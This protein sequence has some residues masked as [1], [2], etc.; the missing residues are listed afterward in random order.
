MASAGDM[1]CPMCGE[2]VKMGAKICRHCKANL[3]G[4]APAGPPPPGYYS[5]APPPKK[6]SGCGIAIWVILGIIVLCCGGGTAA[7]FVMRQEWSKPICEENLKKL[8]PHVRTISKNADGKDMDLRR[9]RGTDFWRI[10][11]NRTG[12]KSSAMCMGAAMNRFREQVYRGPKKPLDEIGE[13]DPI[14]CCPFD[15]HDEGVWV[16]YKDGSYRWALRGSDDFKQAQ[17]ELTD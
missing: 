11:A 5:E 3:G 14:G 1:P 17:D 2:T 8:A 13:H 7:F 16:I 10:L 9:A 15:A 12:N 4:P 6:K